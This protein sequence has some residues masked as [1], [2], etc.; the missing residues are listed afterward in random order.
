M[1]R[2]WQV[3]SGRSG[4]RGLA[5]AHAVHEGAAGWLHGVAIKVMDVHVVSASEG[6]QWAAGGAGWAWRIHAAAEQ[7]ARGGGRHGGGT[8]ATTALKGCKSQIRADLDPTSQSGVELPL[9]IVRA[10][11]NYQENQQFIPYRN[12]LLAPFRLRPCFDK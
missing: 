8:R 10:Q 12:V 11:G 7:A 6:S 1:A 5:T 9:E 3:N 4:A 2:Q